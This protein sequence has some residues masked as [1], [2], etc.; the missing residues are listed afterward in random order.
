MNCINHIYNINKYEKDIET[1][2]STFTVRCEKCKKL[3][4]IMFTDDS[5][6]K[7]VMAFY[8]DIHPKEGINNG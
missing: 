8:L 6:I 2:I 4:E 5:F 3:D 7:V 1:G